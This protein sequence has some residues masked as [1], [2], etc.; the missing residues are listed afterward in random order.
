ML[1][2]ASDAWTWFTAASSWAWFTAPFQGQSWWDIINSPV[3]GAGVG[4]LLAQRVGQVAK[5]RI[6]AEE[7]KQEAERQ[8]N[9]FDDT[10]TVEPVVARE[11]VSDAERAD[12]FRRG[13]TS[14]RKLK[15]YIDAVADR[16][17]DG[18]TKR[19]YDNIGRKDYRVIT[20]ALEA[21][22]GLRQPVFKV[23]MSA[24]EDWRSYSNGQSVVPQE[25]A[26]RLERMAG[27]YQITEHRPKSWTP[28]SKPTTTAQVAEATPS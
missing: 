4:I 6:D 8:E 25:L 17:K 14:I 26:S 20:S 28:K 23:F 18:R 1:D 21:D 9:L 13:S 15:M 5:E 7:A 3:V 24:F 2:W 16:V 12:R 27:E 11:I 22:G 19:K 10:A